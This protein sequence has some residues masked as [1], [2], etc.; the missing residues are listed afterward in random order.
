MTMATR[1]EAEHSVRV[2]RGGDCRRRRFNMASVDWSKRYLKIALTLER[3]SE[4]GKL[5]P[6]EPQPGE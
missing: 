2:G 1:K 4:E 3:L 6:A 5:R